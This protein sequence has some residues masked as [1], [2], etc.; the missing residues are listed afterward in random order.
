M[1][2]RLRFGETDNA[3]RVYRLGREFSKVLSDTEFSWQ[4][5]LTGTAMVSKDTRMPYTAHG[6]SVAC[7]GDSTELGRKREPGLYL[8]KLGPSFPTKAL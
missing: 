3:C 5:G 6:S 4:I 2:H 8:L 7:S 1:D